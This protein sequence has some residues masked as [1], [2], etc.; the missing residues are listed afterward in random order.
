MTQCVIHFQQTISSQSETFIRF[1]SFPSFEMVKLFYIGVFYK[2]QNN[3]IV[4]LKEASNLS[5]F[6]FFQRGSVE[7]FMK[8]TSK[9]VVERSDVATRVSV[10]EKGK[11][12]N[13]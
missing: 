7:E 3:S 10:T 1:Q 2:H 8:F 13:A 9:V 4:T 12:N 11:D 5:S 6:G